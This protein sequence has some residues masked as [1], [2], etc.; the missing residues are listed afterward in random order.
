MSVNDYSLSH[1]GQMKVAVDYQEN[2]AAGLQILEQDWNELYGEGIV[3]NN[4]SP[5][6]LE[7]WYFA[8]WA[9]NTGIE[10]TAR[11]GNTTGCTPG[12][13]CTGKDGTWGLGWTNNP[14]NPDYP[15]NR[16]P[17]L[18]DTYADAA[19]PS[20]WAYQERI[21]GWMASPLIRYHYYGYD[22]PTYHGGHSWMQLPGVNAFCDSSNKCDVNY[23]NQSNPG[24]SYCTLS[25]FQCWWHKPV[26]WVP[27][28][29]ANCDERLPIH[30]R[31][32]RTVLR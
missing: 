3:A 21:M 28:C 7:N 16:D 4:G 9:Y 30:D 19:H 1:H 8:A 13:S 15:P 5:K 20:D 10:P 27:N 26:T 31:I 6:Y 25:D 23:H 18:Q 2:I 17:Y 14:K 32:D 12:P 24:A 22:P 11:F 29:A